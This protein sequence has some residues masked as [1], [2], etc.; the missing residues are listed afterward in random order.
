[1]SKIGDG[2]AVLRLSL[3]PLSVYREPC[4]KFFV[5]MRILGFAKAGVEENFFI[6]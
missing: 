2:S 3:N 4:V 6:T 1:M 5:L